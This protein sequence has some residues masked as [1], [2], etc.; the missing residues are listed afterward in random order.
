[1]MKRKFVDLS[2][3]PLILEKTYQAVHCDLE[4]FRGWVIELKMI[5]V[6]EPLVWM[7]RGIEVNI[8]DVG[9]TWRRYIPDGEHHLITEMRD[10][11]H[12]VQQ[13]YIDIIFE[14]GFDVNGCFYYDDLYL[15]LI[16]SP[17]GQVEVHDADELEDALKVG[18]ISQAQFDLAW[19]ETNRL[20][21]LLETGELRPISK[22]TDRPVLLQM[23]NRLT[24]EGTLE[25]QGERLVQLVV[26]VAFEPVG[27]PTQRGH[28]VRVRQA[29]RDSFEADVAAQSVDVLQ[30]SGNDF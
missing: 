21:A 22:I 19:R 20:V 18:I 5:R 27:A 13:W 25:R 11:N 3:W 10:R 17:D 29:A 28:E 15:D 7:N 12:Q 2:D 14:H 6:L 30:Q 16:V 8:A 23:L 9:N 1:M 26:N 24:L 4:S